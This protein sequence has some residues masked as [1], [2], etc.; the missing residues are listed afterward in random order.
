MTGCNHAGVADRVGLRHNSSS[1][2][3]WSLTTEATMDK[4]LVLY[5]AP[6]AVIDEWMKKPEQERKSDETKM[7]DAWQKWMSANA[8]KFTDKGAGAGKPKV[9]SS[10]GVK[11]ARNDIMMYQVVQASSADEAAKM[12]VGHPHFGIPQ[13]TIEVMPLKAMEG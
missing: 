7:M 6:S 8:S 1:R 4:F 13:A 3:S 5:K 10:S 11:D 2:L 9:V 12:F